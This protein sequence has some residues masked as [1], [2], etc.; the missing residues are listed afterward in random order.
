M[1][2]LLCMSRNNFK[3][4]SKLFQ[5]SFSEEVEG[6]LNMDWGL[7]N[8]DVISVGGN[9][10]Y[11]AYLKKDNTTMS[12]SSKK[13]QFLTIVD[14]NVDSYVEEIEKYLNL[15]WKV[16]NCRAIKN[17][18]KIENIAFLMNERKL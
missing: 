7:I 8:C 16:I 18:N 3:I 17:N 12:Y 2:I 1:E 15:D 11:F 13:H 9:L 14:L 10:K 4:V 5:A 6:L